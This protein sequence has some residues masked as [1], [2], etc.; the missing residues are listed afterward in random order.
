MAR[1]KY[2]GEPDR[3]GFVKT[4]GPCERIITPR[5]TGGPQVL[6]PIPPATEFVKGE[7][8][9]YD[10]TDE[11]SLQAFRADTRYQEIV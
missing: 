1:F 3:P 10:I 6:T 4:Y 9:G 2:L 8:I 11:M 7:D 5:K